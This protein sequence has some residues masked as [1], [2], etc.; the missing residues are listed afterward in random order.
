MSRKEEAAADYKHQ[1]PDNQ[2][3][4]PKKEGEVTK[5]GIIVGRGKV[6]VPPDEVRKLASYWCSYKE[7]ADWFGINIETLKYNFH[8]E[9]ELGRAE[10]K[11]ALRKA[12]I[13][14]AL[15]GDRTMLIWLGKN[16]LSQSDNPNDSSA[17]TPLPW[18]D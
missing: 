8:A 6:V 3:L 16:L 1:R 12:Q 2:G 13:E 18:S 17:S 11:Q 4:R 14:T 10:T 9:I 7:I 5:I 15:K